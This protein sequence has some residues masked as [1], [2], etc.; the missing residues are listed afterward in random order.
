MLLR[1][2]IYGVIGWAAEIVWTAAYELVTG[3]RKDPLDPRVRVR[4]TPPERWKLAGHTYLWM[5]PL[6]GMG[7][8]A[9][10]PCHEWIRHWPWPIRGALWAAGIFAVEYAFG[11]LLRAV[12]GRCPWDYSYA[13]WHVHGLVRLDY[14]PVWFAFGLFLERL[15]DALLRLR[16]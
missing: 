8:L 14:A 6:Y 2:F 16:A 13:R 12:S 15:H 1:F 4:M 9:F 7:G 3:T 10:E 5:F 11:R